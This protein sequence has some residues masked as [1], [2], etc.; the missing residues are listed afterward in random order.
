MMASQDGVPIC[1]PRMATDGLKLVTSFSPSVG[2]L[3]WHLGTPSWV[4]IAS[5]DGILGC[6]P[7]MQSWDGILGWHPGMPSCDGILGWWVPYWDAIQGGTLG[8]GTR[9]NSGK[10]ICL[11]VFIIA[12]VITTFAL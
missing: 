9:T 2:I 12:Q 1:Q 5:W 11:P 3:G 7:G 8:G 6:H 10:C 4:A